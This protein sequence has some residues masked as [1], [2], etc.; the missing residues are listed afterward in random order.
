MD[1]QSQFIEANS[2]DL[3]IS[4]STKFIDELIE[5]NNFKQAFMQLILVLDILNNS[6]KC[7]LIEHY[8]H[9]FYN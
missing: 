1:K 7:E 4:N 3:Y 9:K 2:E 5:K 8:H 6:Q